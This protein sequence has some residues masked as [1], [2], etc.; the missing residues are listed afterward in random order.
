MELRIEFIFY[1]LIEVVNLFQQNRNVKE[2]IKKE[3]KLNSDVTH[4]NNTN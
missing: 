3:F 4:Q 2:F 1:I